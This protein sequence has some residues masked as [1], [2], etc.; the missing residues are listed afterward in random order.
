MLGV[1]GFKRYLGDRRE[2]LIGAGVLFALI[3]FTLVPFIWGNRT[4]QDS[5]GPPASLF[6]TGSRYP[7]AV[8]T[9]IRELD[10]GA[11]A[12]GLEPALALEHRIV[13][14]EHAYPI[15]NPY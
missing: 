7:A 2:T 4:L 12:W 3:N 11:S 13:H 6:A 5:V 8:K 10:P 15:W 1:Q 9:H 14:A